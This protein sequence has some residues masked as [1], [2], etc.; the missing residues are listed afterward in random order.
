MNLTNNHPLGH[1]RAWLIGVLSLLISGLSIGAD[2]RGAGEVMADAMTRMMD[3]MGFSPSGERG[4]NSLSGV[5]DSVPGQSQA[6]SQ[7]QGF[8]KALPGHFGHP[9]WEFGLPEAYRSFSAEP[10]AWRPTPFDGIW[11]ERAGGL[12][13]VRGR[14][15]RLYQPNAGY[16]DGLIQQRGNRV[17]LY[18]PATQAARPYEFA[19]HQS[20]LAL[21]DPAGTLFLYRRLWM[22]QEDSADPADL[23]D[24][25]NLPS[26]PSLP[27]LPDMRDP[28]TA[29]PN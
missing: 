28:F 10:G 22:E 12:L 8:A 17:A 16:V 13:I 11:E 1:W 6:Q 4:A 14:R 29:N 21:R 2:Q 3:A 25:S 5:M 20:R 7:A 9:L 15:F 27:S 19:L 26:L 18:N 24:P 23:P